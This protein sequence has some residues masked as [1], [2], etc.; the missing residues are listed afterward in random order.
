MNTFVSSLEFLKLLLLLNLHLNIHFSY[1]LLK[2]QKMCLSDLLR[3]K[4]AILHF[5][6][7]ISLFKHLC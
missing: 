7:G 3:I 1:P 4:L 6:L 2:S 5:N